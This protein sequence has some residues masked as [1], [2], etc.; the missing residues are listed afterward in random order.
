M[1]LVIFRWLGRAGII[2][3]TQFYVNPLVG[4]SMDRGPGLWRA[5]V[6]RVKAY[7]KFQQIAH[8][9]ASVPMMMASSVLVTITLLYFLGF[10][11]NIGTVM[12]FV[13]GFGIPGLTGFVSM[14]VIFIQTFFPLIEAVV[15]TTFWGILI[16]L[17]PPIAMNLMALVTVLYT[18]W[19]DDE[20]VRAAVQTKFTSRFHSFLF[21]F[22]STGMPD[23]AA[24]DLPGDRAIV[25][26]EAEILA[27]LR[28]VEKKGEEF[29]PK[30]RGLNR[31]ILEGFVMT[32][33]E[34]ES[35]LVRL[36]NIIAELQS[37]ARGLMSSPDNALNPILL[38]NFATRTR[39]VIEQQVRPLLADMNLS[40]KE[41]RQIMDKL[42]VDQT[43]LED[44]ALGR[45]RYGWRTFSSGVLSI[46]AA[47]VLIWFGFDY[48][49]WLGAFLVALGV[50]LLVISTINLI[51]KIP[52]F[53]GSVQM[54]NFA[55][56]SGRALKMYFYFTFLHPSAWRNFGVAVN[57]FYKPGANEPFWTRGRDEGLGDLSLW[58]LTPWRRFQIWWAG[59][60]KTI[61]QY[62][63]FPFII[64]ASLPWLTAVHDWRT[65]IERE[66]GVEQVKVS[67]VTKEGVPTQL[68]WASWGRA[69][70]SAYQL[71]PESFQGWAVAQVDEASRLYHE[72]KDRDSVMERRALRQL[73][74]ALF[75]VRTYADGLARRTNWDNPIEAEKAIRRY[76]EIVQ[77]VQS[78]LAVT[79]QTDRFEKIF[80]GLPLKPV[81]ILNQFQTSGQQ[82][83]TPPGCCH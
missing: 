47:L 9:A 80:P 67:I 83:F 19:R 34:K 18:S 38:A 78:A 37:I 14:M 4:L 62:S 48:P 40:Q 81:P 35:N 54:R 17:Y 24:F 70:D 33:P 60:G 2:R 30:F 64:L 36:N 49:M 79:G 59:T 46:V 42:L 20:S 26:E 53:K 22:V 82:T 7:Y 29:M 41:Q 72:S 68:N 52:A 23:A 21:L 58:E 77:V 50:S 13:E 73:D 75:P 76:E 11:F 16:F 5:I 12:E 44:L 32:A 66:V 43:E 71:N 55:V 39:N 51:W 25:R 27:K 69:V 10:F 56:Q 3:N 63:V 6:S 61:L 1:G 31:R 65:K 74:I 57:S 28:E 8:L 45:L 15:P